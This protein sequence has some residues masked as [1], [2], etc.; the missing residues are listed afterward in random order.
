[1]SLKPTIDF[2]TRNFLTS[3]QTSISNYPK[4][5]VTKNNS[6]LYDKYFTSL[7]W[8]KRVQSLVKL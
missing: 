6:Y 2:I 1:M 5:H 7:N 8:V 4:R 3:S